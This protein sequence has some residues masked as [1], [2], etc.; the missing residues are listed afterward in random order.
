METDSLATMKIF[1]AAVLVAAGS[2]G[3]AA[4]RETILFAPDFSLGLASGWQNVAF[5]KKLTEYTVVRDGTN[6]WVRG[7]AEQ[8]CSALSTKLDLA[9]PATLTLRWRWRIQGVP[10]GGSERD[11]SK[12]DHAAR[13]F[14]AF[15]TWVGPPLTLN[16]LWGDAEKPGTVL[17][18]PKSARAQLLVL[19][20][21]NALAGQWVTEERDVTADWR[22][23]FGDKA[24]PRIVGLGLM[25][26]ADSLGQRLVG[27]YA[28]IELIGK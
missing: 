7:V 24:M 1:A 13:V 3:L 18:H 27:D 28:D 26:D 25:T 8:S 12:F 19:Q 4:A 9:V 6:A 5:F 10:A 14:I 15:D 23:V 11:L 16:Y 21:G 2:L 20:S 22:R 17:V